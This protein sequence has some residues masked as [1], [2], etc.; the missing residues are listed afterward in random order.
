MSWIE[1]HLPA[2]RRRFLIGPRKEFC[3]HGGSVLI[4]DS[5]KNVASFRDA[6]GLAIL[7]PRPWNSRHAESEIGLGVVAA[8]LRSMCAD[9]I[10]RTAESLAS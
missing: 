9:P 2:Y 4:D 3:A 1:K 7:Y 8:E 5:D 10:H 6:G